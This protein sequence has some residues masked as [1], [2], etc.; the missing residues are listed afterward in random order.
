[1]RSEGPRGVADRRLVVTGAVEGV[2]SPLN[3]N[4]GQ[5]DLLGTDV[6]VSV[7]A[8]FY[9]RDATALHVLSGTLTMEIK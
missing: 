4:G 3:M 6:N 7:N 5:G 2:S 8:E 9:L 1:M